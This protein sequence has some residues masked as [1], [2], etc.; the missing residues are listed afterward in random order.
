MPAERDRPVP[1]PVSER[2]VY[3]A[4]DNGGDDRPGRRPETARSRETGLAGAG[5]RH[6]RSPIL[7]LIVLVAIAVIIALAGVAAR[8]DGLDG[9]QTDTGTFKLLPITTTSTS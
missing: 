9:S 8:G 4:G 6:R 1:T 5:G 7:A 3:R 2:R